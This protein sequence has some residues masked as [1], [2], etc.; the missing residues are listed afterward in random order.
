M[1]IVDEVP[2]FIWQGADALQHWS[3]DLASDAQQHG[4]TDQKVTLGRT[5]R[6]ESSGDRAYAIVD[7]VY[8]F[9]QN[10]V[11]NARSR[12]DDVRAEQSDCRLAHQRLGLDR[13]QGTTG[14]RDS[15]LSPMV[16]G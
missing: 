14:A 12:T 2:P 5:T 8:S 11:A 9:K 1:V 13:T 15:Y 10:G 4:I 6:L 16:A 7:A 3:G